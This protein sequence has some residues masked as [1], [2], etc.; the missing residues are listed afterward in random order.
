MSNHNINNVKITEI[1]NFSDFF[2]VY[3]I[4]RNP[5]YCEAWTEEE[6]IKEYEKIKQNGKLFGYYIQKKCI[7]IVSLIE[8]N[9][10]LKFN[11]NIN[12]IYLSDLAVL[13]DYRKSLVALELV[14]F[15]I[16]YAKQNSFDKI[17]LRTLKDSSSYE[18]SLFK[19]MGF[20][21]INDKVEVVKRTRT[22][23]MKEEDCRFYWQYEI[24]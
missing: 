14:N 4:Y 11:S 16:K 9:Q 17:Y 13:S 15:A 8:N 24:V 18:F 6:I 10:P 22:R 7:G 23:L 2:N 19:K 21:K 3:K 20:I 1:E 12:A 5:P